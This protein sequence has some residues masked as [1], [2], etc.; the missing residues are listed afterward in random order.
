MISSRVSKTNSTFAPKI[1]PK[2]RRSQVAAPIQVT[3]EALVENILEVVEPTLKPVAL[4]PPP[5]Q[6][7]DD[8]QNLLSSLLSFSYKSGATSS[9]HDQL[10]IQKL[11]NKANKIKNKSKAKKNNVAEIPDTPVVSPTTHAAP[12]LMLIDGLVSIGLFY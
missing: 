7:E 4:A 12:K 3:V 10:K 11:K 5:L 2:Q 9:S 1:K 8:N 6:V